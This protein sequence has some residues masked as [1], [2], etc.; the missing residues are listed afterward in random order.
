MEKIKAFLRD[1]T[2][3]IHRPP[4]W[5]VMFVDEHGIATPL[6]PRPFAF[7][8]IAQ[9]CVDECNEIRRQR[10]DSGHFELRDILA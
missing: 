5:V 8:Y 9:K 10:G 4:R 3:F 1:L 6:D 7:E 2:L